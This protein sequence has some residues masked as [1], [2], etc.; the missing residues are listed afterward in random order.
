MKS[1][2]AKTGPIPVST[3]SAES[4]PSCPFKGNG[5]YAESGPLALHWREVTEGRRGVEWGEFCDQVA[6]MPE[7]QLWRHNQ[8]GD[9]PGHGDTIDGAALA[10]LVEAN[11]GKRG[12]TYTHKP[13]SPENLEAIRDAN[14]HGFVV[15]VSANSPEE[16]DVVMD[17][18][19]PTV[20]VLPVDQTE[21]LKTVKGRTI[22]VCPAT[23]R[24]GVSCVSCQLCARGNRTVAIGFPAHGSSKKKA[25]KVV[26]LRRNVA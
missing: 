2:N 20:C 17:L 22:V 9:L 13:L 14:R 25:E 16:V 26:F 24:D 6:T 19:L 15:N 21:N 1:A 4:C 12:F 18:G 3:T 7:G 5:C 10:R 8:A 23:Q 11:M